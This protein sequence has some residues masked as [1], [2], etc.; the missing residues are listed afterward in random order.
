MDSAAE[1]LVV[2][3]AET[4]EAT[5]DAL[6]SWCD[7]L[8]LVGFPP[9][10][11]L[12]WHQGWSATGEYWDVWVTAEFLKTLEDTGPAETTSETLACN[13]D[14][15]RVCGLQMPQPPWGIDGR[16]P[17]FE[18]CPCC[19]V[20]FGYAD[21]TPV[22]ARRYREAWLEEGARWSEPEEAP[23]CWALDEQLAAVP[24]DFR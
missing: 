5:R 14:R 6:R 22:A 18:H 12:R 23:C 9:A 17:T 16:S 11:E 3:R 15:C 1:W 13:L 7:E 19:G 4:I 10:D 20:E 24:P 21:A 8:G 2:A